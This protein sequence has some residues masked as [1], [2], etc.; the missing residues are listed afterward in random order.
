MSM[1]VFETFD[2]DVADMMLAGGMNGAGGVPQYLGI[3]F[4][5]ITPGVVVAELDVTTD[6]LN[7]FGAAHGATLAALVD[8]LLGSAVFPLLPR[9]TWPATLEFKLNYLAPA[10]VGVLRATATVVSMSKRTAVIAVDCE[11]E[12]RLV[13]TALG[14]VS[15]TPPK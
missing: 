12:G 3:R 9:G 2:Q 7:P 10:R 1:P 8:H 4:T 13:G 11:N 6:L 15:I 5:S 14:T